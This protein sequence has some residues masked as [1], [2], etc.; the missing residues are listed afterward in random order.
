MQWILLAA[1]LGA[2]PC[3]K[4]EALLHLAMAPNGLKAEKAVGCLA[5][6]RRS[7]VE[8][9]VSGLQE[10]RSKAEYHE[11]ASDASSKQARLLV[12]RIRALRFLTG[13]DI[14]A[15]PSDTG[16]TTQVLALPVDPLLR[17]RPVFWTWMSRGRTFVGDVE[18]QR[19]VIRGWQEWHAEKSTNF[20]FPSSEVAFDDWYF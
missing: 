19:A 4:P 3:N 8:W 6:D 12:A 9:L 16:T 20:V 10:G 17:M 7:S 2:S 18:L 1:I 13:L 5:T 14:A 15:L 11:G